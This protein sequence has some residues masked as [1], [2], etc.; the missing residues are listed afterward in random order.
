MTMRA[1][2]LGG[3]MSYFTGGETSKRAQ[4]AVPHFHDALIEKGLLRMKTVI[5][6]HP[7]IGFMWMDG[8]MNV[9]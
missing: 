7:Q 3:E 5:N 1:K 9:V 4:C 8:W 6:K 2:C